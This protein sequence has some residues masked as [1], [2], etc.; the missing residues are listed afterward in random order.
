MPIQSFQL[1]TKT[2]SD[3]G[4]FEGMVSVYGNVDGGGD[5]CE[6]GCFTKTLQTSGA[7]RPLLL[8]HRTPAIGTVELSD[9]PT[10]LKAVGKLVMTTQAGRE[11]YELLKARAVRGMS[12]GYQ[13]VRED[14]KGAVRRLLEV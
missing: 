10:G 6:P 4:E 5:I 13:V 3:Q 12:F 2:L 14:I 11:A 7:T 9:T 8:E 1:E